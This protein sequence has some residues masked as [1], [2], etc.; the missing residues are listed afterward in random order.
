MK[1]MISIS[2]CMS[3]IA[4]NLQLK[5]RI[6]LEKKRRIH[7]CHLKDDPS[8]ILYALKMAYK[9]RQ[10]CRHTKVRIINFSDTQF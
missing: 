4:Q 3:L 8:L 1:R 6:T 2:L 5:R 7:K 10:Q 9:R